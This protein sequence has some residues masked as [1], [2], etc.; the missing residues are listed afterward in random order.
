[1]A[2]PQKIR[3]GDALIKQRL[4]NEQQLKDALD[5]QR[6]SGKKLGRVVIEMG[7]ATENQVA[8]AM[9]TQL[10][11]AFVDL[12]RQDANLE[13]ARVLTENQARRFRALVL[14]RT[15]GAAI[16]AMSDPT[17]VLVFDELVRILKVE[18]TLCVVT[19]SAL[20]Q[21][22]DRIYKGGS[23][24]SGIAQ[25][26]KQELGEREVDLGALTAATSVEDA[27]V[28]RLLRSI[29]ESAI[30]MNA[31][32][33][34]I[35]P[36]E[37]HLLIRFR[38]DGV[39][40]VQNQADSK[41][42]GA[43]VLRLKLVAG[44]DISEKRL[45]QDG[46]FHMKVGNAQVDVRISTLATQYGESAVMRLLTQGGRT[47]RLNQ[48]GMPPAILEKVR[49]ALT[50]SSGM[51]LVTGPTGSGKTTTLYAALQEM[52]T[53]QRKI[54]TVEDPVEYRISGLNQVQVLEK[55]DL[56]FA[57]V[58]RSVLRQDPDVI[59][60][61]EMRDQ[62]T[63]ETG[64]RA[65]MTGHMVF[66]TLHTNDAA[67]TPIRLLNMGAP[68]YMVAMSLQMV[69]AQRLLR[70]ICAECKTE[71]ALSAQER[72]WLTQEIGDQ[73]ERFKFAAGRGCEKCSRT[74][75]KG[76]TGIYE[77]LEMT[78]PLIHATTTGDPKTFLAAAQEQMQGQTLRRHAAQ[79]ALLGRTTVEEAMSVSAQMDD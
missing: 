79:L 26:L 61:G 11:I 45:P 3:L 49:N 55:I 48:L 36:Q 8:M 67:S 35:E 19:E 72:A 14:S 18:P 39:L 53:P 62:G 24:I 42:S 50:R 70:L 28:V 56:T 52:N 65:A 76:R 73:V 64:L 74:G 78:K 51:I 7:L 30:S 46:R 12:D 77:L 68:A 75:Y 15:E 47:S 23:Q 57:R 13:S 63:V 66:S 41:I 32:D 37:T 60:V 33:I 17:D 34:H 43:L 5:Q 71:H 9:A 16:V 4:I 59:L 31:S 44:L 29:F 6:K 27:P 58:L 1:M 22:F 40:H 20:L 54:I 38:I 69:L 21:A 25:E 10:G 2:I